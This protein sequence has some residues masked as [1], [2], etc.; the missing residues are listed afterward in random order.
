MSDVLTILSVDW[1][2]FANVDSEYK[3]MCFPDGGEYSPFLEKIIWTGKYNFCSSSKFKN[4][5]DIGIREKE[6]NTLCEL[7]KNNHWYNYNIGMSHKSIVDYVE[8]ILKQV[9]SE[10]KFRVV[11]IDFHHD[12]YD[13]NNLNLHCG[14]WVLELNDRG[15]LEEYIWVRNED[16]DE[17]KT[18]GRIKNYREIVDFNEL[19]D[20][21]FHFLYICK[22][23]LWS[24][25]HLD[26]YFIDLCKSIPDSSIDF[27]KYSMFNNRY[28]DEF[29]NEVEENIKRMEQLKSLTSK[30][31]L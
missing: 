25:P 10:I 22:S 24:P 20:M 23:T 8:G 6:Y 30:Y 26:K 17:C 3:A 28:N 14:N 13:T 5:A 4:L 19:E 16:S 29:K 11:N 15:L 27:S 7:I 1:D 18:K 2:Y 31:V 21:E 9:G 12:M